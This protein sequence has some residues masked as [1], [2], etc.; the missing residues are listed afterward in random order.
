MK[1]VENKVPTAMTPKPKP[2][3]RTYRFD[4]NLAKVLRSRLK[5]NAMPNKIKRLPIM[6]AKMIGRFCKTMFPNYFRRADL[7]LEASMDFGYRPDDAGLYVEQLLHA[8]YMTFDSRFST[9]T[10][11][12]HIHHGVRLK[13]SVQDAVFYTVICCIITP[14]GDS[15]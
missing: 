14:F 9:G 12:P 5:I 15:S 2:M 10:C 13:N 3:A 8:P 7:L 6:P 11:A 4:D 1:T